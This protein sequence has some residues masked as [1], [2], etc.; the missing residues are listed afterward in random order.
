MAKKDNDQRDAAD[1]FT[2]MLRIQGEAARQLM[3]TVAPDME[4]SVPDQSAVDAM[5]EAMM[6]FQQTWFQFCLPE[7]QRP[8]QSSKAVSCLYKLCHPIL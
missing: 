1:I 6:E 3:Q 7:D 8:R 5:G 2:E 4:S